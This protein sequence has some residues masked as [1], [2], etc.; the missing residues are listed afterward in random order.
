MALPTLKIHQHNFLTSTKMETKKC[1]KCGEVKPLSMFYK[2]S[3][4]KDGY[5]NK[6]KECTKKDSIENYSRKSKD[7]KWLENERERNREKFKRL[8]YKNRFKSTKT[9]SK[10]I[11]SIS[12]MA[13][14]RG[15]DCNNKEFHHWNYN[16]P[17][18]VF[19]FTR[20]THRRIHKYIYVNYEDRFTYTIDNVKIETVD[21]AKKIYEDIL[22]LEGIE[23]NIYFYELNKIKI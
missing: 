18:S 5:L 14:I 8:N 13:R 2:H 12:R 15:I 6:C 9:L 17:Y 23:E 1:F 3:K 10:L 21:Q 16:Y 20:Y 4:M 19:L 7:E 22:K 11:R